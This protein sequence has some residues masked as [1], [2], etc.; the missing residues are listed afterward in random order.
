MVVTVEKWGR[1]ALLK[2]KGQLVHPEGDTELRKRFREILE[3]QSD[4]FFVIDM[5]GVPY[6][7]SAGLGELIA[8]VKRAREAGG[9]IKFADLNNRVSDTFMLLG[10]SQIVDIYAST[11][12]AFGAYTA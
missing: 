6:C 12:E 9:D 7:D 5:S 2:L 4:P 8:C 3:E 11:A 1:V 10:M